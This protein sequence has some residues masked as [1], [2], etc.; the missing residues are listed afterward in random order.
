MPSGQ[1]QANAQS[2]Y[3]WHQDTPCLFYSIAA[4]KYIFKDL[5]ESHHVGE[6]FGIKVEEIMGL[7][8]DKTVPPTRL[9]MIWSG[10]ISGQLDADRADYLLASSPA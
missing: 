7:L 5:I 8:G 3:D 10:L 1:H 6:S 4:I 9:S 2:G